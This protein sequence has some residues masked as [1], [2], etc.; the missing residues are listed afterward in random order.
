MSVMRG[1]R[2][3]EKVGVNISTVYGTLGER[4]QKAMAARGVPGM[5]NDP[6]FW[7]AGISLVAHMQNPQTP[8]VHMNTR[9]LTTQAAWFGGGADLNPPIPYEEDT[10][11]FHAAMAVWA[12]MAPN[13]KPAMTPVRAYELSQPGLLIQADCIAIGSTS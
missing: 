9:F 10:E 7:A 3:F 11:E 12:E 2:V 5:E 6:R 13:A 8:A 4:A 1:G